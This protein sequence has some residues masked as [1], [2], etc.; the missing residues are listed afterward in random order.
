MSRDDIQD[1]FRVQAKA[2]TNLGSPFMGVLLNGLADLWP[3]CGTL[4]RICRGFEGD[5]SAYGHAIALRAAGG[6]HALV[7]SGRDDALTAAY[8]PN[9][10]DPETLISAAL[11]AFETHAEFFADWMQSP[12]QTNEV[13]RSAVLIAGAHWIAARHPLPFVTSELGASGGLNTNWDRYALQAGDVRLGPADPVLTLT[14]EWAGA[15]PAP[16]EIRVTD[17]AAVDLRPVDVTDPAQALRMKAYLWPDQP[18]RMELTEAAIAAIDTP[19]AA[20]DAADWLEDRLARPFPGHIHMICHTIA[21]QYFPEPVKARVTALIEAAGASATHDAPVAW[22]SMEADG[23]PGSA[24][25]G[26]RL[27]PG[28]IDLELGR[29]DYH[30]RWIRWHEGA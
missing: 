18:H 29:A 26:L 7:L 6:L 17:K 30:G 8:P 4:D 23:T 5:I 10:T 1:S 13:R 19:I 14:P 22:L 25:I 2:C 16:A 15:A 24:R 27:W 3:D 21:W 12:P 9:P 28:D 11:A 20:G